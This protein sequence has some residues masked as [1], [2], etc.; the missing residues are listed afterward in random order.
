[1][2]TA[3]V[4][5]YGG[6]GD[7][8]QASSILPGLKDLGYRIVVNTTPAGKDVLL[9]DPHVDDWIIQEPGEIP[10]ERLGDHWANIAS[11][12]DRFINLSETVEGALYSVPRRP[13]HYWPKEARHLTMNV[14][15]IALT[16]AVAGV[17]LPPRYRFYATDSERKWARGT[18]SAMGKGRVVLWVLSGSSVHKSWPYMDRIIARAMLLLP[19]VKIVLVGEDLAKLLEAGWENEPRVIRKCGEWSVRKTL[20]FAKEADLLIGPETGILYGMGLERI[21]KIVFLSHSSVGNLYLGWKNCTAL[22]PQ[23]CPCYPCHQLH[24]GF[25]FCRRDPVT[26]AALCQARIDP[27]NVWKALLEALGGGK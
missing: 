7:M 13:Q 20:S 3:V 17:P 6:I 25:E 5:R 21:P 14:D 23:G 2:K 16:H 26:G 8:F 22:L 1:M 19:D 24:Y 4:V 9:H 18:R 15:A 27:E 10:T 12:C 11:R